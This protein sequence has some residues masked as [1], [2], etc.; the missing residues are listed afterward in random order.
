MGLIA[1]RQEAQRIDR[2]VVVHEPELLRQFVTYKLMSF[3]KFRQNQYNV[4]S[5][6]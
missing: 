4:G 3:M 6:A 1:V 5:F 2:S